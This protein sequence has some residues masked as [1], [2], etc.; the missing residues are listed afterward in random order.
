MYLNLSHDI[1]D[2][3]MGTI[4]EITIVYSIVNSFLSNFKSAK[5]IQLLIEGQVFHTLN[6]LLYTYNPLE[7]NT[8]L[9]EE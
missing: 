8:N 3:E 2:E 1:K 9:V 6:G 7:F 4:E 5:K